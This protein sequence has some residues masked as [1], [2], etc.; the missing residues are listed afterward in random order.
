M[1][2]SNPAQDASIAKLVDE[3]GDLD[4]ELSPILT[5]EFVARIK[6]VQ[7][8]RKQLRDKYDGAQADR[9]YTAAGERYE[10]VLGARK[11]E[12]HIHT[13]R[14]FDRVGRD[15]FLRIATVNERALEEECDKGIVRAVC[16][17]RATGRR[18][19]KVTEKPNEEIA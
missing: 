1:P 3:I 15:V 6:K 8:L 13:S 5:P 12:T 19:L 18:P 10:V 9:F 4:R 16:E 7:A 2:R 17:M 14:L 11:N